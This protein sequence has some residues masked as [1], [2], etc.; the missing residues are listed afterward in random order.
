MHGGRPIQ[1]AE[2]TPVPHPENIV[3][4]LE[5]ANRFSITD[6]Y[7]LNPQAG[8]GPGPVQALGE[9]RRRTELTVGCDQQ[10]GK[11]PVAVAQPIQNSS[12]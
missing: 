5:Q 4:D 10:V 2:T 7:P 9:R 6:Q 12:S 1:P 3:S 11:L 8:F